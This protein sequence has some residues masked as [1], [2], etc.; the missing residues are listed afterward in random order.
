[1]Q[2]LFR[3]PLSRQAALMVVEDMADMIEVD[4]GGTVLVE[5]DSSGNRVDQSRTLAALCPA[6]SNYVFVLPLTVPSVEWVQAISGVRILWDSDLACEWE[7][8]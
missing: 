3:E 5:Y 1:M 8:S 6:L 4:I 7:E 2:Q